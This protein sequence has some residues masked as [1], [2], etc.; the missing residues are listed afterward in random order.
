MEVQ[1]YAIRVHVT[2]VDPLGRNASDDGWLDL[3]SLRQG[4]IAQQVV[5]RRPA[6]LDVPWGCLLHG[7]QPGSDLFVR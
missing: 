7:L 1:E 6:L 3:S 4:V 5:E 2:G